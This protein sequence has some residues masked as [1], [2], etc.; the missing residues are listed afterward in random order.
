MKAERAV[1]LSLQVK[2][3]LDQQQQH[4]CTEPKLHEG[5]PMGARPGLR[6]LARW[7]K[8]Q[9]RASVS[10]ATSPTIWTRQGYSVGFSS[11]PTASDC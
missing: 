9:D 4:R 10:Q 6:A 2:I 11:V 7:G 1:T 8:V 3:L 5:G